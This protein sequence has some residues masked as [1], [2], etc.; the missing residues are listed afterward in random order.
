[1]SKKDNSGISTHAKEQI[2]KKKAP[3][4]YSVSTLLRALKRGKAV[5]VQVEDEMEDAIGIQ[6]FGYVF[7][8]KTVGKNKRL[9]LKTVLTGE[10]HKNN[11]NMSKK[12]AT[13][14]A[15]GLVAR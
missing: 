12:R 15:L 3:F 1:M 8:L 11:L 5:K 14:K 9:I 6:Y 13:L 4:I 7:V 10:E 2:L